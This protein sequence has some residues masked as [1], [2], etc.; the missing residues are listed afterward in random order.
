MEEEERE[1]IEERGRQERPRYRLL[2][3]ELQPEKESGR[4]KKK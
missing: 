4:K 1:E 3:R 2:E